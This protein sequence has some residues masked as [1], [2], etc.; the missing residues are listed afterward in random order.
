MQQPA[1][2]NMV[3][4]AQEFQQL[5][6]RDEELQELDR[7]MFDDCYLPVSGGSE[8]TEGKVNILLQ[9]YIGKQLVENFSLVSD[10]SYVAQNA[11]RIIRAL[12]E[13]VLRKGWSVM[14]G[15]LLT[16][17]KVIEHQL[18]DF[19]HPLRQFNE[20][21]PEILNKLEQFE[22]SLDRLKEM[23]SNEIE[24]F[25]SDATFVTVTLGGFALRHILKQLFEY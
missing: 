22:L 3:S 5:K 13:I 2:L 12:F 15:R 11:G 9:T 20:L 23:D 10:M 24:I 21:R 6:V 8:S 17:S 1:I 7:H 25:G 14:T 4:H 18:W 19:E 16:L